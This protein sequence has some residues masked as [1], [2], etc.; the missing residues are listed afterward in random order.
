MPLSRVEVARPCCAEPKR[1]GPIG[2]TAGAARRRGGGRTSRGGAIDTAEVA[3]VVD[4]IFD[5]VAPA[6]PTRIT[7]DDICACKAGPTVISMLI[8]AEGF[9]AYDRRESQLNH[10]KDDDS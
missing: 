5:M 2:A 6:D 10:D 7:F 9:S 3:D 4:E 1:R 8:D